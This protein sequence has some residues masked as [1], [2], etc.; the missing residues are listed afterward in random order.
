[1]LVGTWNGI[2]VAATISEVGADKLGITVSSGIISTVALVPFL[3]LTEISRVMGESK[4]WSLFF[5]S[6]KSTAHV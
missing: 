2:T 5:H 3:I 4:F 6:R 1:V